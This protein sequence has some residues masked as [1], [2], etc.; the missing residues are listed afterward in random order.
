MVRQF[1]VYRFEGEE[2]GGEGEEVAVSEGADGGDDGLF[3][4]DGTQVV[5]EVSEFEAVG[6]LTQFV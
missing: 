1:S 6:A 5:D 2:G 4:V 3:G